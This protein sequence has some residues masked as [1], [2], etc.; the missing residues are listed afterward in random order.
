MIAAIYARKSTDQSSVGEE[1]P[2]ELREFLVAKLAE[3][4]VLDY[5]HVHGLVLTDGVPRQQRGES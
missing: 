5:Y 4:L 2:P 3:I 1:L